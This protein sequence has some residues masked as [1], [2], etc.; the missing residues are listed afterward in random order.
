[1]RQV[2]QTTN[3]W[4]RM[5]AKYFICQND[6]VPYSFFFVFLS[7]FVRESCLPQEKNKPT[8]KGTDRK[9]D[10]KTK[11]TINKGP[12]GQN[13]KIK[14]RRILVHLQYTVNIHSRAHARTT[15]HPPTF[16]RMLQINPCHLYSSCKSP[17]PLLTHF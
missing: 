12:C 10:P 9:E 16:V 14:W 7:L 8:I 17:P 11:E 2:F 13:H 4:N 1:V 6:R 15:A 3:P 5:A